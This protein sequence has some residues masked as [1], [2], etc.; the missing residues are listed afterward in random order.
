MP[1]KSRAP[2]SVVVPSTYY[3]SV[4]AAFAGAPDQLW[5]TSTEGEKWCVVN[6]PALA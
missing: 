3:E 6:L 2:E 4:P 5:V 1:N